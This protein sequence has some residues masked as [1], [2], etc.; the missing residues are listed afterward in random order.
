MDVKTAFLNGDLDEDIYMQQP[1]GHRADGAQADYVW[2]LNKSLYGLKQA[3][4]VWN[5]KIHA[6]L[7]ELGFTSLHS[8]SCVYCDEVSYVVMCFVLAFGEWGQ[9]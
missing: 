5:H 2:K 9:L 4:R 3:D 8:D 7:V 6:A 1:E